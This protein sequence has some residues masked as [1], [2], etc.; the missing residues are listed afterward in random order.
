[1]QISYHTHA[2]GLDLT[3]GYG[4]AGQNIVESLQRLGHTTPFNHAEAPVGINFT[5]PWYYQYHEGQYVIGYTPWESTRLEE[6]WNNLMNKCDEVWTTSDWCAQVFKDNGV[7][8]PIYVYEHGIDHDWS[9]WRRRSKPK[10]LK[11]LH[12]GEPALRKCG[13]M[14]FQAFEE[15]F[16]ND[17]RYSMTI[18]SNG[19][20]VIRAKYPDGSIGKIDDIY[21]NVRIITNMLSKHDLI[22]LYKQ[23]DVLIY[24]SFGEG[25]GLIP[26]QAMATGMPVIMNTTWAPYRRFSTGLDIK[27]RLIPSNYPNI[28][29]GE[30]FE[31]D[32]ESL[33]QQM[34]RAADDFETFSEQAFEVA[35]QIHEEY[36]W[37]NLTRNAFDH[38]VKK[39]S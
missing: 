17:P 25:F 26:L 29:P 35:P 23:H 11:F 28:H 14:A 5:Q 15:L 12:H 20:T 37:T 21:D 38:I 19:P 10:V 22:S 9:P 30:M 31:P 18:K 16:G 4:V 3:Q 36:D 1:M 39:F 7:T 27:D 13:P 2:G 32:F 8:K 33:K 6:N 24:P 34:Q